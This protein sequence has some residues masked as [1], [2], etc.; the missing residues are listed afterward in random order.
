MKHSIE[1]NR[2]FIVINVSTFQLAGEWYLLYGY[3]EWFAHSM[4]CWKGDF[5]IMPNG[6]LNATFHLYHVGISKDGKKTS[7]TY[8]EES[9]YFVLIFI[10]FRT[11]PPT[12]EA[13]KAATLALEK[14]GLKFS[15]FFHTCDDGT[16]YI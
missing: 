12:D 14:Q 6:H 1:R 8:E 9:P 2:Q 3:P 4:K 7:V 11:N 15:E 10:V 16:L 5:Q 13:V